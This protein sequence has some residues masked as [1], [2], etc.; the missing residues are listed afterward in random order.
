MRNR[1]DVARCGEWRGE[2]SVEDWDGCAMGGFEIR[3][4]LWDGVGGDVVNE[5]ALSTSQRFEAR[6]VPML[7]R[8]SAMTL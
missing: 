1:R 3:K 6:W 7:I 5:S 2:D 4:E 8:L